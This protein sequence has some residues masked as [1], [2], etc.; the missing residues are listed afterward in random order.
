MFE[1]ILEEEKKEKERNNFVN[2][3]A[4]V[5]HYPNFR[6]NPFINPFQP[7]HFLP[8]MPNY[9]QPQPWQSQVFQ[10]QNVECRP[11]DQHPINPP[12][13]PYNGRTAPHLLAKLEGQNDPLP[14]VGIILPIASGSALKFDCNKDRKHYFREVQNIC[15]EG[16]VER[17]RWSHI[18]VTFSEE[19]VRLQGFPH[20]EALVTEANIASSTL[21]KLLVDNGSSADII[22]ADAYDK[23]GLSRDLLQ[24]PD[25]P[26]YGFGG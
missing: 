10:A 25:I 11:I 14:S 7:P 5:W 20:N 15:V 1:A 4:P 24:P 12:P 17:T 18:P 22:F 13:P 2:H 19:N 8:P 26:L 9:T 16:R 6:R 3:S 23:M 21:G